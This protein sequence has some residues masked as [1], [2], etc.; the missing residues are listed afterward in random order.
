LLSV[1]AVD[2][3][4]DSPFG[5]ESSTPA[6]QPVAKRRKREATMTGNSERNMMTPIADIQTVSW[7][8]KQKKRYKLLRMF[9]RF[10]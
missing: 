3:D 8:S 6:P 7:L 9:R 4:G 2:Q 5:P 1:V 10:E